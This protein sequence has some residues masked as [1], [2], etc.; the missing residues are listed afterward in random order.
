MK[1][2]EVIAKLEEIKAKEGD[3][4]VVV[5]DNHIWTNELTGFITF[6]DNRNFFGV[7]T[8]FKNAKGNFNRWKLPGDGSEERILHLGGNW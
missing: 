3:I 6:Q 2:S 5:G 1:I 7:H 8:A 4:T